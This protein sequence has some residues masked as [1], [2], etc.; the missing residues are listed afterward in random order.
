VTNLHIENGGRN[1]AVQ[2]G[3]QGRIEV[4]GGNHFGSRLA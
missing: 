2:R 4:V 1:A 3:L